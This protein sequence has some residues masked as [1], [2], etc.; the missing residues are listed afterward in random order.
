MPRPL[1]ALALAACASAFAPP[2]GRVGALAHPPSSRRGAAAVRREAAHIPLDESYPGVRFESRD[3]DVVI[4]EGFLSGAEC[5]DLVAAGRAADLE[6]SPV[7]YAGR[8]V[9]PASV[10]GTTR[11]GVPS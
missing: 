10:G 8:S 4:I 11:E 5:D 9:R 6:A 3:P 1:A 7:A 2:P